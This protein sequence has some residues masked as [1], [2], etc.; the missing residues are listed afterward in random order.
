MFGFIDVGTVQ[1][2]DAEALIALGFLG[3]ASQVVIFF[4]QVRNHGTVVSDRGVFLLEFLVFQRSRPVEFFQF[5]VQFIC[6]P[7]QPSVLIDQLPLLI[8][9]V[10]FELFLLI[11]GPLHLF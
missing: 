1:S 8:S 3:I 2:S 10:L 5:F 9:G 7:E 11:F 4:D 6:M